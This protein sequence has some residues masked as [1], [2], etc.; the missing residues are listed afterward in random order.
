MGRLTL[1]KLTIHIIQFSTTLAVYFVGTFSLGQLKDKW[2]SILWH[3][4]HV[5]GL[6]IITF[7]GLFDW[8]ITE[9]TIG[10]KQFA[11]S[12]QEVLIS[13]ALYFAMGL[14]NKSL[15]KASP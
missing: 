3:F 9:I 4:V 13:P 15:K 2:M 12:I 10:L 5:S 6:F 7:L 8:F 1:P 11:Y 14:L